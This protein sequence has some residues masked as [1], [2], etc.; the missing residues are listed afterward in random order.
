M[1]LWR[2]DGRNWHPAVDVFRLLELLNHG[3]TSSAHFERLPRRRWRLKLLWLWPW[4]RCLRDVSV[5][6]VKLEVPRQGDGELGAFR[7]HDAV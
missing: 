5:T 3:G 4:F 7:I 2:F 1:M 6:I